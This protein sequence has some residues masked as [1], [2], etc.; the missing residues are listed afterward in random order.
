MYEKYQFYAFH[1]RESR[2]TRILRNGLKKG[3]GMRIFGLEISSP[4]E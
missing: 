1:E 3:M 4:I 2:N